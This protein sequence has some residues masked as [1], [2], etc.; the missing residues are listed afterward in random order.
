MHFVYV[1]KFNEGKFY[2]GYTGDLR[3]R[4]KEHQ[5]KQKTIL[6]YYEAYLSEKIKEI[7]RKD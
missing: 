2:I 4:I 1:L 3:R 7:E 6:L 5:Q